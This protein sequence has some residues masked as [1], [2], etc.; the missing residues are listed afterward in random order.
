MTPQ[1]S[2]ILFVCLGNI[3]R[4]PMA[5]GVMR[6]LIDAAGL[7]AHISVDSAGTSGWHDGEPEHLGTRAQ[8]KQHGINLSEFKSRKLLPQDQQ[9]FDYI[10]VMDDQNA[11]DTAA[12]FGND[13]KIIK[14]TDLCQRFSVAGVPDPWFTHDFDE[15]YQI[16]L[17]G[18]QQLLSLIQNKQLAP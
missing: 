2:A 5:E 10:V 7:S 15:T 17:D 12:C 11:I 13:H 6:Q 4:S 16:I 3:C 1:S 8:L 18:C 14:L 9:T